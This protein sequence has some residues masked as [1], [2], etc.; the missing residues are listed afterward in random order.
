MTAVAYIRRSASGEAQASE[1]LQRETVQ[2]LAEQQG[3]TLSHVYRD[4]GRS[5]GSETRPQYMAMLSQA[6]AG[7]VQAIY[8]YDQDR[9]A[10][11]NWLFAGLL[12]L[13][14]LQGFAIITP[15]GDLTDEDRR[16]FAEM[17]GVMDGGEL[18]KITK[19]NRAIKSLKKQRGDD[20]GT[21]AFG[22]SKVRAE[23]GELNRKGIPVE[24]GAII[25][26][27]DDPEAIER[28]I[29]AYKAAGTLLGAAKALTAAGEPTPFGRRKRVDGSDYGNGQY[30]SSTWRASG[31]RRIIE[32]EAPELMPS[33]KGVSRKHRPRLFAKLLV[34]HCGQT[35]TPGGSVKSPGYWCGRG[36]NTAGH[37][38][39]Y[40]SESRLRPWIEAEAAKYRYK[41]YWDIDAEAKATDTA[42]KRRRLGG[43]RDLMS[44]AA[45]ADA[46]AA[47]EAEEMTP[48]RVPAEAPPLDWEWSVQ[49][50]N[51]WLRAAFEYVQLGPDLKPTEATWTVPAWRS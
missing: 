7:G 26:V 3:D 44:E 16:D 46:L 13:A 41:R 38:K 5:G 10:R 18:R 34:C 19:R 1:K 33:V 24:A 35:L 14:D 20:P 15:A 11:S 47:I 28:V 39:Y 32:R 45:Y 25:D 37:G 22:Y 29:E 31:V 48:E 43:A 12:R 40:I 42:D 30:K 21:V 49:A 27:K 6:E 23:G 8:A 50:I 17:R 2:Q 36:H 9:L 51:T 4:W